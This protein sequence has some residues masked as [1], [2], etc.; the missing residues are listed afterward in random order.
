MILGLTGY[1]LRAAVFGKSP[2]DKSALCQL[3]DGRKDSLQ[4]FSGTSRR[5]SKGSLTVVKAADVFS[6]GLSRVKHEMRKCV[7]QLFPGPNILLLLVRPSD[8]NETDKQKIMSTISIFGQNAYKCSIVVVMQNGREENPSVRNLIQDC[9]Q[10]QHTFSLGE[11]DLADCDPK[12]LLREMESIVSDNNELYLNFNEHADFTGA[13]ERP[14]STLN[15]AICGGHNA[16]KTSVANSILGKKRFHK[17]NDS[18][19]CD[20]EESEV[21]GRR[22]S[23]VILPALS[24]KPIE[25]AKKLSYNCVSLCTSGHVDA[26]I[27]V[28]PLHNTSED[29]KKEVETIREIFGWRVDNLIIPLLVT[30]A[31]SDLSG[32][33]R[34]LKNK[35]I[36]DLRDKYR[37]RCLDCDVMDQEQVLKVLEAAEMMSGTGRGYKSSMIPQMIRRTLTFQSK[38]H[39]FESLAFQRRE[40]NRLSLRPAI[41]P[42]NFKGQASSEPLK[43]VSPSA[44]STKGRLGSDRTKADPKNPESV[45]EHSGTYYFKAIS[46]NP[47]TVRGRLGTD[48]LNENAKINQTAKKQS[49]FEYWEAKSSIAN[50]PKTILKTDKVKT[51]PGTDKIRMS[52]NIDSVDTVTG[53]QNVGKASCVEAVKKVY[54]TDTSWMDASSAHAK[55]NTKTETTDMVKEVVKGVRSEHDLR[56]L[57]VGKTGGGKSASGNT[58]LGKEC[59][60]SQTCMKSVTKLCKK[61]TAKIHGRSV[62]VVDTPG[63]FDTSLSHDQV[64]EELV[65]CISLLAP[66]PHVILLVLKIGRLT[67][68]EKDSVEHIKTFFGKRSKDYI[69]ILF[70]N[71]EQLSGSTIESFLETDNEGYIAKI[72]SE[73]GQRY[74]VFNNKDEKNRSQVTQLLEKV[75]LLVSKN[76]G[77]YY[78]SAMFREAEAA[79]EKQMKKNLIAVESQIQLEQHNLQREHQQQQQLQKEKMAELKSDFEC[80]AER[81]KLVRQNEARIKEQRL[82][83]KREQDKREEEKRRMKIQGQTTRKDWEKQLQEDEQRK[84]E[85]EQLFLQKLREGYARELEKFEMKRKEDARRIIGEEEKRWKL[86]QEAYY[87]RLE[88]IRKRHEVAA[89]KQA[90]E[91]NE[92]RSKFIHDATAETEKYKR[93]VHALKQKGQEERDNIIGLLCKKKS[94]KNDFDKLKTEQEQELDKLKGMYFESQDDRNWEIEE[95]NKAHE[96]QI[97]QWVQ[98]RV[99]KATEEKVCSIL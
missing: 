70:T 69:I 5:M 31:N 85:E 72:L 76:G 96:E 30:R 75:E 81:D 25:D 41:G 51:V 98:K 60:K 9:C 7:Q 82:R 84:Q 47:D 32:I 53:R 64:K 16:L 56:L 73:C 80:K 63:L 39:P 91:Y 83:I 4:E 89:R 79:I 19:E 46:K 95:L 94:Y 14:S 23:L 12:E 6:L 33:T 93:E 86:A 68:E 29:D 40:K 50:S 37:G 45:K 42:G 1:D 90:E 55:V 20:R 22:V 66:G 58:I 49:S 15:L 67:Q 3:L 27:L 62:S 38:C 71:G 36:Q 43:T 57:L 13:N 92:F 61:E 18:L 88:E 52:T 74:H 59:F 21:L 11:S 8:F 10:R 24:G 97:D 78:T 35:D 34:S 77:G 28:V 99:E 26:F 65:K 87:L 48:H 17:L 44:N 54:K 2:D